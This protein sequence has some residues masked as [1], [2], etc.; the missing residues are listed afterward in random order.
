[1][2]DE[3][4]EKE[5]KEE[6]FDFDSAGE[7][8]GY[9]SLDQARVLAIEHAG[10]N[11]DRYTDRYARRRL[12]YDVVSA[13]EGEDYYEVMLSRRPSGRFRGEPG[14]EQ[15]TIDKTGQIQLRQIL[16][17]P[18]ETESAVSMVWIWTRRIVALPLFLLVFVL[19]LAALVVLQV[20]DNLLDPG[21][22]PEE[23]EDAGVYEFVLNDL[24][25]SFLNDFRALEGDSLPKQL[26]ENPL[27]TTGLSSEEIVRSLNRGIP[28]EWVKG[29]VEEVFDE[30][31]SYVA[32]DRDEFEVRV[33]VG[34]QVE[35]LVEEFKELAR[36]ADTY[37]LLF[38]E[39]VDPSIEEAL[40]RELPLGLEEV[41]AE[42]LSDSVRAVVPPEWVQEQ[43][44]DLLDQVTP[45]AVGDE[46]SFEIRARL[47]PLV[48]DALTEVK[49]LLR[50]I[51]AYSLLYDEV[52][53]PRIEERLGDGVQLP[54]GI[55]VSTGE[56]EQALRQAAPIE[57]VQAEVERVID[58]ASPYLTGRTDKFAITVELRNNKRQARALILDIVQMRLEEAARQLPVCSAAQ[59]AQIS[60]RLAG[61]GLQRL[62]PCMPE[63]I[64][65]GR[66]V[67]QMSGP[68]A[69]GV[70]SVVL[71]SIPDNIVF[72]EANLRQALD[73]A[74]AGDNLELVDDVREIIRDDWT[75][76][77]S[78]LREDVF[79][80]WGQGGLDRLED[81]RDFLSDRWTY[82]RQDLRDDILELTDQQALDDFDQGRDYLSLART[83]RYL[84]YV[85]A[86]LVLVLVGLLGGRTWSSRIRWAA[87]FLVIATAIIFIATGPVYSFVGD[88]LLD[89]AALIDGRLFFDAQKEAQADIDRGGDFENTERLANDK[90]LEILK[91][92]VS[93]FASG[94]AGKSLVLMVIGGLVIGA[95]IWWSILFSLVRRSIPWGR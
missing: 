81:I 42:R 67:D 33:R 25:I 40:E 39:L 91:S 93:G 78:D 6:K 74:G 88:S 51:E 35:D 38:D 89:D 61:G 73:L 8:V 17:D 15:F 53:D 94:V 16:S 59:T 7:S 1:M 2:A 63:G 48:K 3:E 55:I 24:A 49:G 71:R 43:V 20:N 27:V 36:E 72:T 58:E 77:D 14:L 30:A 19:L 12:V 64:Q 29:I 47:S 22:Y 41:S 44:E 52:I 18:R 57:W 65:P 83:F 50:D 26:D 87:S 90:L 70:D 92:V 5:G 23:L 32:G 69:D 45:W 68:I 9:I 28:P 21:F 84:I 46:D 54:L 56:V 80:Q 66:L 95:T 37:T 86:L 10:K 82:T 34:R 62:P 31:G 79:E 85:P 4:R 76:T 60:Q 11:P 75:Y 13:S